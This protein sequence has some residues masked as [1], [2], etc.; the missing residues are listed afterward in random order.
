MLTLSV[1]HWEEWAYWRNTTRTWFPLVRS[2]RIC[3]PQQ[4][5]HCLGHH[6]LRKQQS[7]WSSSI[8]SDKQKEAAVRAA[9][10]FSR[11]PHYVQGRASPT[12]F[13]NV[14]ATSHTLEECR[15]EDLSS[16]QRDDWNSSMGMS[17]TSSHAYH[18]A[19]PVSHGFSPKWWNQ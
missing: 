10:V 2:Q 3:L 6:L 19:C 5:V 16:S 8:P 15:K 13:S 17:I 9:R 12:C 1:P 14:R 18:S 11:P 7:T 4:H